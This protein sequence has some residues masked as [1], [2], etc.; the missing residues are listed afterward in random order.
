MKENMK[1]RFGNRKEVCSYQ[2]SLSQSSFMTSFMLLHSFTVVS[3]QALSCRPCS[4][5]PDQERTDA[6]L[7]EAGAG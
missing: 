4:L 6:G 7:N 2:V 5:S 3:W 1:E